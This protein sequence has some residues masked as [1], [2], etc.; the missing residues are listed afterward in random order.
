MVND[1]EAPNIFGCNDL[2]VNTDPGVCTAV[3]HYAPFATDNCDGNIDVVCQPAS[4]FAFPKGVTHVTC[5]AA[6]DAGN[7][8]SCGFDVTVRDMEKP[9]IA[10][11]GDLSFAADSGQCSR[12]NVNYPAATATD[13]CDANPPIVCN[14]AS[15]STF[16]VGTTA[17]TCTATDSSGNSASCTFTITVVDAEPPAIICSPDL[18]VECSSPNGT[19][20]SFNTSAFDNCPGVTLFCSMA[21]GS[22][23]PPGATTVHCAAFDSSGN[24]NVCSFTVTVTDTTP[25]AIT[26]PANI[27]VKCTGTNGAVVTYAAGATDNCDPNPT[28]S[29]TPASGSVFPEGATTVNCTASDH[30]GHS[31]SCSF[32]VTVVEPP[33]SLAIEI[34]GALLEVSWPVTCATYVLERT[35]SLNAPID[36]NPVSGPVVVEGNR[37][38]YKTSTALSMRY[39]R[40]HKQ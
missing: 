16:F 32:T 39:F 37:Y 19:P 34:S 7:S 35:F 33:V 5:T 21:S 18:T 22:L 11:P 20:V 26:C 14:P 40:L 25:P 23:F 8:T 13:N 12:A 3:A 29:C 28:V 6:D 15:G 2:N 4:G 1:D 38:V 31:S 36:W 10:C 17:V 9:R 27:T 24:G 30:N